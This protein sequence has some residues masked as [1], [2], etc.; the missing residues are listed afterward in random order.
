MRELA[1]EK[2]HLHLPVKNGDPPRLMRFAV[3]DREV[4]ELAVELGDADPVLS[5]S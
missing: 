1:I 2:Q 5:R 3:E 4:R